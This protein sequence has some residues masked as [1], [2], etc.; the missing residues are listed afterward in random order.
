[1]ILKMDIDD[2]HIVIH[3]RSLG[4]AAAAHLASKFSPG[5]VILE[6]SFTSMPDMAALYY[7]Y[8]PARLLTRERFNTLSKII[9]ITSPKL[10]VHSI[11]D[12]IVPFSMGERLFTAAD[13]PKEF[14]RLRGGHNDAYSIS[15]QIYIGAL[16][17]F[18]DKHIRFS[19]PNDRQFNGPV[20]E[21]E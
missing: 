9:S 5:A 1:M 13:I 4:S 15:G 21:K 12:D 2:E 3:G 19:A 17:T 7:P 10:I 6:S 11:N 20:L 14:L 8:L 18:T 16:E